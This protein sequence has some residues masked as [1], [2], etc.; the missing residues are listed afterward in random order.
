MLAIKY[1]LFTILFAWGINCYGQSKMISDQ[2][3]NGSVYYRQSTFLKSVSQLPEIIQKNLSGYLHEAL[4]PI[5]DSLNFSYGQIVDLKEMFKNDTAAYKYEWVV[6]KYDLNFLIH[7]IS[8]G[9]KSYYLR[10]RMDEFG[11]IVYSNWP[12]QNYSDRKRLSQLQR[13]EELA[14]KTAIRDKYNSEGYKV[15]LQYDE[16]L[17]KLFWI[18]YFNSK[19]NERYKSYNVISVDWINHDIIDDGRGIVEMK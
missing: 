3:Y 2:A 18:F 16:K 6:A 5:S 15:A 12:R 11:Q 17:N 9:I 10:I 7:D 14:L 19:E 4:G 1:L 13:I 8:I